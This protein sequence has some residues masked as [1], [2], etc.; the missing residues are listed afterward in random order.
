MLP[1]EFEPNHI[2]DLIYHMDDYISVMRSLESE[3]NEEATL[4]AAGLEEWSVLYFESQRIDLAILKKE[5]VE[6]VNEL[7][8]RIMQFSVRDIYTD[9]YCDIVLGSLFYEISK[10]GVSIFFILQD[11]LEDDKYML[12]RELFELMLFKVILPHQNTELEPQAIT[13]KLLSREY[14]TVEDDLLETIHLRHHCLYLEKDTATSY[15]HRI[16][17]IVENGIPEYQCLYRN[18]P[19]TTTKALWLKGRTKVEIG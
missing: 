2:S 15:I 9:M 3:T 13:T 7:Y 1:N 14:Y 5:T 10:Q 8:I 11:E 16:L 4:L 18:K 17:D 6:L 12:V 19:I